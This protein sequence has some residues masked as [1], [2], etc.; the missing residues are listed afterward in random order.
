MNFLIES[1]NGFIFAMYI[2]MTIIKQQLFKFIQFHYIHMTQ[3][4]EIYHQ[5]RWE[6][7]I[8]CFSLK[9]VRLLPYRNSYKEPQM[10]SICRCLAFQ[11]KMLPLLITL[12]HKI[13]K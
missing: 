10:C 12:K 9:D 1:V 2:L 6:T 8:L 7:K 4:D 3:L 13:N 11:N 5:E